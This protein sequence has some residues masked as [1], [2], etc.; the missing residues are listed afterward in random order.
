FKVWIQ[1]VN[2]KRWI[3][4][5]GSNRSTGKCRYQ[6]LDPIGQRENVDIK[7]WIQSVNGKTFKMLIRFSSQHIGRRKRAIL[8]KYRRKS[9]EK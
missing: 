1:S 8:G 4:K 7:V 6:N 2:G 9:R 5:F 3:L